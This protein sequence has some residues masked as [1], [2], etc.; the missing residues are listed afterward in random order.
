MAQHQLLYLTYVH[1][2]NLKV[3]ISCRNAASTG[4]GLELL[5]RF[6]GISNGSPFG[7]PFVLAL[8]TNCCN[9]VLACI[10]FVIQYVIHST[11]IGGNDRSSPKGKQQSYD[12][13][14]W[15]SLGTYCISNSKHLTSDLTSRVYS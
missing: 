4:K 1:M 11:T 13:F 5:S 10:L 15:V 8:A 3:I 12:L 2:G 6:P 14:F 9:I 7:L